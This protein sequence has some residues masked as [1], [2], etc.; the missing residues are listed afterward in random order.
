MP[1]RVY[2]TNVPDATFVVRR[3]NVADEPSFKDELLD[4]TAYVGVLE[5][6]LIKIEAALP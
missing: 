1:D 6:S 3:V 4:E 2:G 5:V